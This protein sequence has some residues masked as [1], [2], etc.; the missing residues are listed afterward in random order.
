MVALTVGWL[1]TK[2]TVGGMLIANTPPFFNSGFEPLVRVTLYLTDKNA[3]GNCL[4]QRCL[5]LRIHIA[6]L[7]HHEAYCRKET[8][9]SL[10]RVTLSHRKKDSQSD[11]PTARSLGLTCCTTTSVKLSCKA[12]IISCSPVRNRRD[13]TSF[14]GQRGRDRTRKAIIHA[15]NNPDKTSYQTKQS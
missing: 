8:G 11:R 15:E 13:S 10:A 1:T 9:G 2:S 12:M 5:S 14:C 4:A 3:Q 7:E 6:K